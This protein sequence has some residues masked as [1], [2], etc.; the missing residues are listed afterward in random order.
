MK[1]DVRDYFVCVSG[2]CLQRLG[3]DYTGLP[4]HLLYTGLERKNLGGAV[5]VK[6]ILPRLLYESG[7]VFAYIGSDVE[8]GL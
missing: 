8:A 4:L 7:S 5:K 2:T 1:C 6:C 3:R